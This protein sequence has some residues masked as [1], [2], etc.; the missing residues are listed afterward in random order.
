MEIK[1]IITKFLLNEATTE[2]LKNLE[3]WK[4]DSIDNVT[5]LKELIEINKA[6]ENLGKYKQYNV[7][8][9]LKNVEHNIAKRPDGKSGYESTLRMK[10]W[11]AVS[12]AIMTLISLLIY[13]FYKSNQG[14]APKEY[15]A[16]TIEEINLEDGTTVKL[17]EGSSLHLG[18][19]FDN[20]R[21]VTLNGRAFFDVKHVSED[22][23]FSVIIPNAEVKV[24]GTSFSVSTYNNNSQVA[25]K[26]GIVKVIS[27]N[28]VVELRE[29][30]KVVFIENAIAK[31]DIGNK[32]YFSWD[33]KV[34]KYND[35]TLRTVVKDL[36]WNYQV[37][38][39]NLE[40]L[41]LIKCNLTTTWTD[42]S[43]EQIL[44]ELN[45]T[46]NLDYTH[47]DNDIFVKNIN[48]DL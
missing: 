43:L 21:V 14:S 19:S 37:N 36:E 16:E 46:Y 34:L 20:K 39:S 12:I 45:Y 41:E 42:M 9:A 47:K 28:R 8:E 26:E 11:M 33:T 22:N 1:K 31:S 25:V 32:N 27:E 17:D 44:K 35:E 10:K 24:V 38:F 30:E 23:T 3:E 2:E 15:F 4:S 40:N 48:C 6:S 13:T 29:G 5:E 7:N 18:E